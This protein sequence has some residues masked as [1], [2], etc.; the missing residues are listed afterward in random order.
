VESF[1]IGATDNECDAI[2]PL[3]WIVKHPPSKLLSNPVNIRFV[4]CQHC[5]KASLNE[6]S[7]QMDSNILD[8]PEAIVIGSISTKDD[9]IDPICLVPA[10]FRKWAHIMMKEGAA[11]LPEH[12]PY[13]HAIDIKDGETPPWVL[14][15]ALSEKELEVQREWLNDMLETGKIRH[16]KLP[17]GSRILFVP[18][19][20][21]RALRHCVDYR[22][23]NTI[24]I[25]NRYPLPIISE[26][27][28]RIRG[29]RIFT[30]MDLKNGYHL[31]CVKTG[32]E[33]KTAFRCG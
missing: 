31:I 11:K 15:Y 3:W 30:K 32:D 25:G 27:Q 7:L 8:H 10:K 24:T 19:A 4:Q 21:G 23:L 18:K 28:D 20:H 12:K 6:F 26:L 5:T 1:E 13:Y 9:N 16:S 33:W 2:L 14:C 17:A 29:A 22:G